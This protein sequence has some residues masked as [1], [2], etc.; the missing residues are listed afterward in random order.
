VLVLSL[1]GGR[2]WRSVDGRGLGN[3][4]AIGAVA[5]SPSYARDRTLF[6]AGAEARAQGSTVTRLW[7]S[8]DGG[9]SWSL[10]FEEVGAGGALLAGG[11]LVPPTFPRDGTVVL[12]VGSRI[13]TPIPNSWER[14]GGQRMPAWNAADLGPDVISVTVLAAPTDPA[15]GPIVYAGT[16]AGP[17][18]S[19][20]GG[21]SFQA[22]LEGYDG[23][24]IV[25]LAVSPA[26]ASDRLMFAIGLGGTIWQRRDDA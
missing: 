17:Y 4:A 11:L 13:L 23:G 10:W 16:N 24:G 26:F 15:A 9:R 19:R 20:D 6:A 2:S 22:W 7:R 1:D 21:R 18:V 8:T 5:A 25:G 3:R 12:A 14:R